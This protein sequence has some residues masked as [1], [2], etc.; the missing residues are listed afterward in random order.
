MLEIIHTFAAITIW[1]PLIADC[2]RIFGR[3]QLNELLYEFMPFVWVLWLLKGSSRVALSPD[4]IGMTIFVLDSLL[5]L[6]WYW[7]WRNSDD[8]RW[9]KRRKKLVEKITTKRGRLAVVPAN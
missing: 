2:F 7:R 9:K 5:A 8:D 4:A 1:V 3:G 6:L